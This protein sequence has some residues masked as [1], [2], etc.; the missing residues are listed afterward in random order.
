MEISN[1]FLQNAAD[2]IGKTDTG[3]SG[4]KIAE[5]CSSYA[6]NFSVDIPYPTSPFIDVPN[7]RTALL[8]NLKCFSP[9]Q[10][11]KTIKELC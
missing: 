5:Y 11:F 3:L 10:L 9:E 1:T 6:S 7:K 2:I 8:K 4:S